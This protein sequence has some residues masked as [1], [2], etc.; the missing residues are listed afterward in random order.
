MHQFDEIS[1][2]MFYSQVAINGI[3]CW[4]SAKQFTKDNHVVLAADDTRMIY[5]A[6]LNVDQE[7]VLWV[8]T[9]TMPR[10]IYGRLDPNEYNFR[11]WR[12]NVLDVV[13][14]TVCDGGPPSRG[15]SRF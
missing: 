11:V 12:V 8:L 7:G 3:A 10:F 9:N 13:R 14:G 1:G 2:V 4:N 6:D 5:P 15:T